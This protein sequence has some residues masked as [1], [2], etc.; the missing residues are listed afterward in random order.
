MRSNKETSKDHG[1]SNLEV[2]PAANRLAGQGLEEVDQRH[3][4]AKGGVHGGVD[5]VVGGG[6]L[7]VD[8]GSKGLLLHEECIAARQ[9]GKN[10]DGGG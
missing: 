10:G 2:E 9:A 5:V 3:T 1:R 7:G 6:Q 8:P 4:V